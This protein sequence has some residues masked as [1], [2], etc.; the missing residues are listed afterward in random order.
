MSRGHGRCRASAG[1]AGDTVGSD[2]I[3]HRSVGGVFV[4][5]AHGEFVAIG[6]AQDYGAGLF[7][8]F[9]GGGVVGGNVMFE[10]S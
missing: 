7:E 8:A 5:T 1:A 10:N 2:G 9:D 4:R 6:F 3:S